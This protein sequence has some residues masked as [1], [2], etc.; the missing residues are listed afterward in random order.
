MI[1]PNPEAAYN[2]CTDYFPS[3]SEPSPLDSQAQSD[4]FNAGYRGADVS[5]I[6][7]REGLSPQQYLEFTEREKIQPPEPPPTELIEPTF[8]STPG[9]ISFQFLCHKI[10]VLSLQLQTINK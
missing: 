3:C 8:V 1:I 9:Q 6:L 5:D 10:L 2:L 4:D 7:D